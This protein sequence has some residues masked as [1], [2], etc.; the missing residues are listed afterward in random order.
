MGSVTAGR[1]PRRPAGR[2]PGSRDDG[3]SAPVG[4]GSSS[5]AMT[6]EST[7]ID[8]SAGTSAPSGNRTRAERTQ[9]EDHGE[10]LGQPA[11]R[12]ARRAR[13]EAD[14]EGPWAPAACPRRRRPE[15]RPASPGAAP[16]RR[17]AAIPAA[18]TA[19]PAASRSAA[20]GHGSTARKRTSTTG[21]S[22]GLPSQKPTV[23]GRPACGRRSADRDRRGAA[24]AHQGEDDRRRR[25]AT[26]PAVPPERPDAQRQPAGREQHLH[27]GCDDEPR[28][29]RLPE[30]AQVGDGERPPGGERRLGR[31][32]A[33]GGQ[34]RAAE[35]R[36]CRRTCG[37]L[38]EYGQVLRPG[39][40]GQ[41]QDH[42]RARP[43]TAAPAG[44]TA[45]PGR[46]TIAPSCRPGA[47]SVSDIPISSCSVSVTRMPRRVTARAHATRVGRSDLDSAL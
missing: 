35:G 21:F 26:P 40:Q 10:E 4:T 44:P 32:G 41:R 9:H 17:A 14:S 11:G 19:T 1:R 22:A 31:G 16:P 13:G 45:P 15:R 27:G 38:T 5:P 25:R 7:R 43:A 42:A 29:E 47:R 28:E 18:T 2:R 30:R 24:R 46:P 12:R 34:D 33:V 23:A 36:S 37:T 20:H 3:T 6:S 39:Q 8:G